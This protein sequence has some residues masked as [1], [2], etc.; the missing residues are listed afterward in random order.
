LFGA[1]AVG[2]LGAAAL[3]QVG[4]KRPPNIVFILADDLGYGEVGCYGQE[5]IK[6]PNID[7]LAKEGMRF[8]QCYA[9]TTVCAPSRCCLLTGLHTGHAWVRG[10]KDIALRAE[11]R[12]IA[13]VLK[14]AGYAT[15]LIGKW[16]L[17]EP[18]T[19]GTPNK[20][21]FDEFFGYLNQTHAH[22]YWTDYLFRNEEK[23][24]IKENLD[25]KQGVYSEDLFATEALS[26]IERHKDHPFFLYLALTIPH[27]KLHPPSMEPYEKEDW[28]EDEKKLAA[29]VTRMDRDIGR[30]LAKMKELGL[31]ENTVVF[32]ASDNGPHKEGGR[33]PE[34]FKSS[35]PLRGIKR[36]MYEGG[37]RVPMIV[38]WPGRIK[39]GSV[40]EQVWA[41]WD[42]PFTAAEIAGT[43]FSVKGDGISMAPGMAGRE[44]KQHEYLY[45]EFH[46]KGFFQAVRKGDWKGVK[47]G[48]KI[49]V[50]VYDL[51]NDL[52]ERKD[53]AKERPE[54]AAE[55][56]RIMRE[57]RTDSVKFPIT[58]AKVG[59]TK[60]EAKPAAGAGGRKN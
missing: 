25:K 30:V 31:E 45:W 23:I 40:S 29:M 1:S 11:D 51:K 32:F 41:F 22:D 12:T 39:A 59:A 56:E 43:S 5:K 35:G 3:G 36:D 50:E 14:G 9:G 10:N 52:G 26:F 54:I 58:E 49:P 33:K 20:K 47:K 48:T 16:G 42:F 27:A 15:G 53:L 19:S 46:E 34:F 13:E 8:T 60:P 44:Q 28:P 17:G 55:M 18:G 4:G 7:G 57:A 24:T 21:G 38:R 6:T 2:A 37:I